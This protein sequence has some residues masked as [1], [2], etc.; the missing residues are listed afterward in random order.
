[1]ISLKIIALFLGAASAH[2]SGGRKGHGLIGYGTKMYDPPC[3]YACR[4]LSTGWMLDCGDDHEAGQGHHSDMEMATPSPNCYATNDPFLQ[5]LAWC[6]S[7]HCQNVK[8]SKL[9][10]YWK[11]NVAGRQQVQPS[12]KYSYQVALARVT[13]PPTEIVDSEAVLN[14]TSLVDEE[15]YVASFNGDGGFEVTEVTSERYG[16]VLMLTCTIIPIVFSLFR[17]LPLPQ[18][19]VSKFYAYFIDPPV[20]GRHHAVP[21][22]GLAI[23]PT[24]GQALFVAYIWIINIVLSGV[25]F[26]ITWPNSWYANRR[27]EITLYFANRQG[28]LSFVNLALTVLY[29][30]RNNPLLYITNWSHST[31]LLV[32]RW[33]A[34][35]CTLQACLHSAVWLQG[36]LSWGKASYETEVNLD[37]WMWGIIAT[38]SLTVLLPASILPIRKRRY[39]IFLAMHVV[40]AVAAM[41]GSLLHIYYRFEWQ[42]GY[43]IWVWI[44]FAFW[45]F[46]RFLMR[47]L[48]I[49]L[50][51]VKRAY[52]TVVDDDYLKITIPG[53]QASGQA[54]LYFPTLTWRVWE[55]HPFSVAAASGPAPAVRKDSDVKSG[56][57]A[58]D[59]E[60]EG[61][62]A[63]APVSHT[64]HHTH[65]PGTTFFVRR[66]G[67]LTSLLSSSPPTGTMVLCEAFYG[68]EQSI[69]HSPTAKPSLAYPNILFIAGGVGITGILPIL[70]KAH[71]L[72]S[73]LG[74]T[75]LFWGVR[76]APL[77]RSVEELLGVSKGTEASGSGGE[78]GIETAQW[79]PASVTVSI[80]ARFD[81]PSLLSTE[82]TSANGGTTVVVCGSPGMADEVRCA[83]AGLARHG[84]V[85]RLSEESFSW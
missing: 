11:M 16:L 6:I 67:G 26:H 45:F 27:E 64:A 55:N 43:E 58:E 50:G 51:G 60:L 83:V 21:V 17:F 74:T 76:T 23:I 24:R 79:G 20:F 62:E 31:F 14:T 7:T 5:T 28:L 8:M 75:K 4:D 42:W 85:V 44:A 80:G 68:P 19:L 33:I 15:S 12:P 53:L 30:T 37:Y 40:F 36:Y 48:R 38:A 1:M 77:V 73:P 46:D 47:P 39:E 32:H 56:P 9:E 63:T 78:T 66:M 3:A 65:A 69:L 71:G 57:S 2:T 35:I 13:E 18:S 54:Y 81:L 10:K 84:A 22:L 72:L 70:N 25:G 52:V 82:L 34:V 59:I 29:S 49:A 41:V 61:R